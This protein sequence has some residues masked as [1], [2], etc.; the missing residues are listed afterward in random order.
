MTSDSISTT[1]S[2]D[3]ECF[4]PRSGIGCYEMYLLLGEVALPETEQVAQRLFVEADVAR[5]EPS[6]EAGRRA[7]I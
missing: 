5:H 2:C 1:P 3:G 7:R 6:V 4:E